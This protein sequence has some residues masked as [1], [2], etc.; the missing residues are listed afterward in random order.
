MT[1][2]T[3]NLWPRTRKCFGSPCTIMQA[4]GACAITGAQVGDIRGF[5]LVKSGEIQK[6]L[7]K[8]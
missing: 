8:P 7:L 4:S 1:S 2:A 5:D 6:V 3:R